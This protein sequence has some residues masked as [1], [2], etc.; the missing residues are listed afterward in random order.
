MSL[1]D[2]NLYIW[3]DDNRFRPSFWNHLENQQTYV[4][5]LSKKLNISDLDQWYNISPELIKLNKGTTVI[6][7]YDNDMYLFLK[8]VFPSRQWF[9]EKFNISSTTISLIKVEEPKVEEPKV[10]EPRV[11]EPRVEEPKVEEPKVEEPKVEEPKVEEPKVEEPI[12]QPV[13][14]SFTMPSFN[15]SMP[16][17][18]INIPNMN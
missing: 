2:A 15:F 4:S 13:I 12:I 8:S 3:L 9:Q 7:K 17:I 5:W 10:E 11:E 18:N 14:P 1:D 16:I 6:S